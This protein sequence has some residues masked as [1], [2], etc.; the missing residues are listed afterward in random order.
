MDNPKTIELKDN[1]ILELINNAIEQSKLNDTSFIKTECDVPT[2]WIHRFHA[3]D[4]LV[5]FYSIR[6]AYE[7]G[8]E[9]LKEHTAK[10]CVS[11]IKETQNE[12]WS[13]DSGNLWVAEYQKGDNY[14][15]VLSCDRLFYLGSGEDFHI[16]LYKGHHTIDENSIVLPQALAFRS[17]AY[18]EPPVWLR[19]ST[20]N[21]RHVVMFSKKR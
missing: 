3:H 11:P 19:D 10:R 20:E 8:S 7:F 4:I 9:F 12:I 18:D 1:T 13:D 16:L 6:E 17:G 5:K 15:T 14:N 2:I 21:W